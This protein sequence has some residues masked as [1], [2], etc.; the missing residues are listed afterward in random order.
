M[1]SRNLVGEIWYCV[2]LALFRARHLKYFVFL[3]FKPQKWLR[4]FCN[5]AWSHILYVNMA[6]LNRGWGILSMSKLKFD[7]VCFVNNSHSPGA[8]DVQRHLSHVCWSI[9]TTLFTVKQHKVVPSDTKIVSSQQNS[10][11]YQGQIWFPR[12]SSATQLYC[13]VDMMDI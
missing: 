6:C 12:L 2:R 8:V 1:L 10:A 4:T 9:F 3:H 7:S 13:V 11:V 5:F